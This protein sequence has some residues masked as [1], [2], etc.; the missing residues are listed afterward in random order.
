MAENKA[1]PY[2]DIID[3]ALT[4]QL[5]FFST[6]ET[7][8]TRGGF[9][10]P[11]PDYARWYNYALNAV[12]A[13]PAEA[14]RI[15]KILSDYAEQTGTAEALQAARAMPVRSKRSLAERWARVK[16]QMHSFRLSAAIEGEN[17]VHSAARVMD[18]V[19]G[20]DYGAILDGAQ[21][22]N[23]AWSKAKRRSKSFQRQL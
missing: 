9:T 8:R 12:R 17:T 20:E 3:H 7:M 19:L 16:S 22:K 21:T 11:A 5:V 2:D 15:D 6:L 13:K 1:D 18:A 14:A 23:G 10:S 4:I